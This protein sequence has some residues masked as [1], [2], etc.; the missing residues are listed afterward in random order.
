MLYDK[1]LSD[2]VLTPQRTSSL[3]ASLFLS[4]RRL[5]I[6]VLHAFLIA[7][8]WYSSFAL[9]FDFDVE[10]PYRAAMLA[11]LPVVM[12]SK[13]AIFYAFNLFHGWW[14]FAGLSD[15]IDIAMASA[16]G[17]IVSFGLT[18]VFFGL[19]GFPRSVF[20][21]D[22]VLT[23]LFVGGVRFAVRAYSETFR[24][25]AHGGLV[26]RV[27]VV[28]AGRTGTTLV[29]EMRTNPAVHYNPVAI[30]DDDSDKQ[31]LKIYGVAVRGTTEDIPALVRQFDVDEVLLAV[32]STSGG[33]V[34]RIIEKAQL[35]GAVVKIMPGV[36]QLIDGRISVNRIR[37][38][39]IDDLL[40]REA[41]ETD[42][43]RVRANTEG[44]VVLLTGA[45]G[46]IGSE[47]SRQ[48]ALMAPGRLVLFDRAE[49]DL[50]DL[51]LML[52]EQLP[53]VDVTAVVGDIL[54][55]SDLEATFKRFRPSRVYHAAAYKHVALMERHITLA[56]RNNVIGTYNVATMAAR[57]GA[58]Q[59]VLIST[60]KAVRP[61]SL[62]GATKRAAERVLLC[63]G[64]GRTRFTAVRFGNVLGSR[65][66][67][68]PI[69]TRQI[70]A[71]G[72]VTV[73]HPDV[74]RF[75]MTIPEAVQLVL[76]AAAMSRGGEVFHLDM[77]GPVRIAD[78]AG[79]MIRLSGFEPGV[80][81]EIKFVGLRPGEKLY[82]ELLVDGEE[83]VP[84]DH[85]R[86]RAV[87]T[88]DP[89][90]EAGWI[91]AV[92]R[93]AD[94]RET[95]ALVELIRVAVPDYTPSDLVLLPLLGTRQQPN[96]P[97]GA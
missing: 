92:I 76:Q 96:D 56:V 3:A 21:L 63:M 75:F 79:N 31:G 78:L 43:G 10:E 12:L 27:L 34:R 86:V 37:E 32:P 20:L 70:A 81:I 35:S 50:H 97:R 65:G 68:V 90:V 33:N 80:D 83:V 69:F 17:A 58:E 52:R 38:V 7:L 47:L 71:G 13:L 44:L 18:A 11:T 9:R 89:G 95:A 25:V 1:K 19:S 49:S 61:T 6:S 67:V 48:L 14:K 29:R 53:N 41:V 94:A 87:S 72:P 84:T 36:D 66:S 64:S 39:R 26:K 23:F 88:V 40:G 5:L 82:E 57:Y 28:G 24:S 45:A 77:G 55:T 85:P 51:E 46:S 15:L 74:V 2:S 91:D 54:D 62:M 42:L 30:V 59:C 60:D 16:S 22:M 4:F 93:A 73:T 8:A